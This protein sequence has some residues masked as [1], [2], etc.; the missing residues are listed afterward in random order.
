[1][2]DF[3][4]ILNH[5]PSYSKSTSTVDCPTILD[6]NKTCLTPTTTENKG[7]SKPWPQVNDETDQRPKTR[8]KK[9]LISK[10]GTK[11]TLP[12]SHWPSKE[13]WNRARN[14]T[15]KKTRILKEKLTS[16]D[17]SI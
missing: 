4:L 14:K 10:K 1:M 8:K 3:G 7:M 2:I 17:P 13:Q 15:T 5:L 6:Y 11:M 16:D 9:P 12:H